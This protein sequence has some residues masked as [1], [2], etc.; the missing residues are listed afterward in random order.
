MIILG[1]ESSCDDT[2]ASLVEDG[3]NILSQVTIHQEEFH[4]AFAGVV[5][6]IAS[7]RHI[8]T[9]LPVIDQALLEAGIG[10]NRIDAVAVT[11]H[12]GLIGSLMIGVNTAKALAYARDLPLVEVNHLA[13]H[14]YTLNLSFPV[15]YPLLG[16]IVSG[17]H[18]L[19]VKAHSPLDIHILGTT[20]DDACGECF[21]KVAKHLN[22]G[23]PGGPAVE[24]LAKEGDAE[25]IPYPISLLDSEENRYH[26]S[27]S[28]L[29]T[30]VIHHT[31]RLAP[32]GASPADICASFQKAALLPLVE[33]LLIASRDFAIDSMGI[34]GGVAANG[35]FR[36]LLEDRGVS[37]TA[38]PLSLCTDNASMVAGLGWEKARLGL[39]VE[40]PLSLAP[41]STSIRRGV[42]LL[43]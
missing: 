37:F 16:L 42:S 15:D 6:E 9:L 20:L 27:Y 19:L 17:G 1:I 8:E 13:A 10:L 32:K 22:I 38:P 18:T 11:S 35:L 33:K 2:A 3:K 24:D 34:C 28:G 36:K 41:C 31:A 14:L 26:F 5:P 39:F 12:P 30:A 4:R 7:R 40:S 29:K 25:R 23:F 43:R 21:D